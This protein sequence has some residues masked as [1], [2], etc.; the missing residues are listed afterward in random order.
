MYRGT[1][2][3][4][5]VQ[6]FSNKE[7]AGML[8]ISEANVRKRLLAGIVAVLILLSATAM[9]VPPVRS[10]IFEFVHEVYEPYVLG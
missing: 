7:I 5:Y 4:K 6:G 3:L 8:G 1:L 10:K 9:A 2:T